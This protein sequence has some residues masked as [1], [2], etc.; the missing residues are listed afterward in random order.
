M[1]RS[2][3]AARPCGLCRRKRWSGRLKLAGRVDGPRLLG[4]RRLALVRGLGAL[5][6]DL[7][8][9]GGPARTLG[10]EPKGTLRTVEI[11]NGL[12]DELTDAAT[13]RRMVGV[14]AAK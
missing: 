11:I 1:R 8:P 14:R 4:N 6:H 2:A 5:G 9:V 13:R 7:T 12:V 10:V 3:E